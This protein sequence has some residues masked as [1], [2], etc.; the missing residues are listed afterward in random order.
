MHEYISERK[1]GNDHLWLS[2]EMLCTSQLFT[3]ENLLS[4]LCYSNYIFIFYLT[5]GFNRLHKD[6]R[7]TRQETFNFWDLVWLILEVYQYIEFD[8]EKVGYT[9]DYP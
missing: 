8:N 1:D 6:N 5:P 2:W 4:E 7:K 3:D 9:S